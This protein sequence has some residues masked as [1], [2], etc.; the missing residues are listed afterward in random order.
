MVEQVVGSGQRYAPSTSH[1]CRCSRPMPAMLQVDA[2]C[3]RRDVAAASAAPPTMT[4]FAGVAAEKEG[5]GLEK[6]LASGISQRF[7]CRWREGPRWPRE[8]ACAVRTD[9]NSIQIYIK[10][11]SNWTRRSRVALL[12]KTLATHRFDGPVRT[13]AASN[14]ARIVDSPDLRAEALFT[15]DAQLDRK[16]N[17]DWA[18]A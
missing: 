8:D 3:Q 16:P 10:N 2:A 4:A 7:L 12:K 5:D 17:L 18:L 13:R 9:T 11:K 6:G 1:V 15:T 14:L